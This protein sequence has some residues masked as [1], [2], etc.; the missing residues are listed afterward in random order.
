MSR[1]PLVWDTSD[2]PEVE[3]LC[4]Q[5]HV[6]RMTLGDSCGSEVGAPWFGR[7]IKYYCPYVLHFVVF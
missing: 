4:V 6:L 5:L 3:G 7:L 1:E 2:P